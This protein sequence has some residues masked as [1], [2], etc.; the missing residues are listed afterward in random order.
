MINWMSPKLKVKSSV[1]LKTVKR[2]K[3]QATS[4]EKIFVM[5][6]SDNKLVSKIYK[7]PSKFNDKKMSN[8]IK[9]G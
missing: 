8:S 2:V 1:L 3:M 4:Q 6:I 5:H 9:N 7:K